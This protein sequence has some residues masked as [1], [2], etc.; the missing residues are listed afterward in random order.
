MIRWSSYKE[1]PGGKVNGPD[2][3][4]IINR[5]LI[6][7][8]RDCY[9]RIDFPFTIKETGKSSHHFGF[10]IGE[11]SDM[12]TLQ[13]SE[14]TTLENNLPVIVAI[15]RGAKIKRK[16]IRTKKKMKKTK[17]KGRGKGKKTKK[18]R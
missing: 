8:N 4:K 1:N 2:N 13:L 3:R 16:G 15:F 14:Q 17:G 9:Y 10:N 5:S 6:F 11:F 7:K 12:L 18:L